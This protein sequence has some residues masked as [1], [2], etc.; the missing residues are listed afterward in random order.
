MAARSA[1]EKEE[2]RREAQASMAKARERAKAQRAETKRK[3]DEGKQKGVGLWNR[4]TTE[5]H[6]QREERERKK[7][8]FV[9]GT[10]SGRRI[11]EAS[12]GE[13][14]LEKLTREAMMKERER[15]IQQSEKQ[16]EWRER[17]KARR[18]KAKGRGSDSEGDSDDDD[19]ELAEL[20][21]LDDLEELIE[22][23]AT[24][25]ELDNAPPAPKPD[26]GA[27][28]DKLLLAGGEE[29]EE[30]EEAENEALGREAG[31]AQ[32]PYVVDDDEDDDDRPILLPA[33]PRTSVKQEARTSPQQVRRRRSSRPLA[34]ESDRSQPDAARRTADDK[35]ANRSRP[36]GRRLVKSPQSNRSTAKRV[37]TIVIRDSDSSDD[38]RSPQKAIAIDD[39]DDEAPR[40]RPGLQSRPSVRLGSPGL[41][42]KSAMPPGS[43]RQRQQAPPGREERRDVSMSP[44]TQ[45]GE[46]SGRGTHQKRG[47]NLPLQRELNG[48]AD[49]LLHHG[50]VSRRG[51]SEMSVDEASP[52]DAVSY[53][54][55]HEAGSTESVERDIGSSS[56]SRAR[57]DDSA[58]RTA[59][60]RREYHEPPDDVPLRSSHKRREFH[61][62]PSVSGANEPADMKHD[63]PKP[64]P[65]KKGRS[66]FRTNQGTSAL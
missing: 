26:Q 53:E 45:R 31:T 50:H 43:S 49:P 58:S 12:E 55:D 14:E 46:P 29:G 2:A 16:R 51:L 36:Q 65:R 39:S 37:D 21:E 42:P 34:D 52:R 35:E 22:L 9:S 57:P 54:D 19:D 62:P 66:F 61:D 13:A 3:L 18:R 47:E 48:N 5:T 44:R 60:K 56:S 1:W 41:R 20:D 40:V 15:E 10:R 23:G 32:N 6:E 63:D 25:A 33:G 24:A 30:D 27:L 64:P 38:G 28:H 8:Q 4:Y 59:A 17:E 11:R 7:Y